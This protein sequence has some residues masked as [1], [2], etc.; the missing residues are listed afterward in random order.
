[1]SQWPCVW[2]GFS[3]MESIARTDGEAMPVDIVGIN[4]L[5]GC[6]NSTW[7]AS[8]LWW[9][10]TLQDLATHSFT[11]ALDLWLFAMRHEWAKAIF[12]RNDVLFGSICISLYFH[13]SCRISFYR[14]QL[15][16][17]RPLGLSE[18]GPRKSKIICLLEA[19]GIF[20]VSLKMMLEVKAGRPPLAEASNLGKYHARQFVPAWKQKIH[21]T[22]L[23]IVRFLV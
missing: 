21:R 22:N 14:G 7:H 2:C 6:W 1:M 9:E 18:P 23:S 17:W 13:L 19:K 8:A 20:N 12:L 16:N 10:S 3:V 15:G 5:C 4:L 11:L